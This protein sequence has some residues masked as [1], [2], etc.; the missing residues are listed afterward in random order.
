MAPMDIE[1]LSELPDELVDAAAD[2][3]RGELH[4]ML[5]VLLLLAAGVAA[6]LWWAVVTL[7]RSRRRKREERRGG[8]EVRF[9]TTS[10]RTLDEGA[11]GSD[12]P[13]GSVFDAEA[14]DLRGFVEPAAA[15]AAQD[16]HA[17]VGAP[18]D[19]AD[20]VLDELA[21]DGD[22]ALE[23]LRQ[24]RDAAAARRDDALEQ[25]DRLAGVDDEGEESRR[26]RW[27][28]ELQRAE[29]E[30]EVRALEQEAEELERE[31][32]ALRSRA[33]RV[34]DGDTETKLVELEAALSELHG[35]REVAALRREQARHA[36][37]DAEE[38]LR[39]AR[40]QIGDAL[41]LSRAADLVD[42]AGRSIGLQLRDEAERQLG[43]D[44]VE[45]YG[46]SQVTGRSDG[47][48][49]RTGDELAAAVD[50]VPDDTRDGEL[51]AAE[52]AGQWAGARFDEDVLV[53]ELAGAGV[54]GDVL[55]GDVLDLDGE[56]ARGGGATAAGASPDDG[57][58][59]GG[60]QDGPPA[61]G[62]AAE[63]PSA[64]GVSGDQGWVDAPQPPGAGAQ[65]DEFA[66]QERRL[67]ELLGGADE[68]SSGDLGLDLGA[69][70][71]H[72]PAEEGVRPAGAGADGEGF[73][74]VEGAVDGEAG[75]REDGF[76]GEGAAGEADGTDALEGGVGDLD[77]VVDLDDLDDEPGSD[78][79][80]DVTYVDPEELED[81]RARPVPASFTAKR[82]PRRGE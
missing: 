56:A 63:P 70:S 39:A 50:D 49:G 43:G 33:E 76:A 58:G 17:A 10:V 3:A 21:D 69:A 28:L 9:A 42:A 48:V 61:G 62:P 34:A 14:E 13:A 71:P 4:E 22:R 29:L 12:Q 60:G 30:Q 25:R 37:S 31:A 82:R 77:D 32:E 73:A 5:P 47:S 19:D 1:T 80:P 24:Q 68:P 81:E 52:A 7:V 44:A 18:V 66:R 26:R 45:E 23:E 64:A 11:G 57:F 75:W 36:R 41:E 27:E 20:A 78:Q 59:G 8:Q 67:D 46:G 38:Q 6:L 79:E 54:D 15:D 72:G 55:D 74:A 16:D 2:L 35:E 51:D 40:E 53:A 65:D